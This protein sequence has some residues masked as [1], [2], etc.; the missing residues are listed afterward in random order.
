M[1]LDAHVHLKHG[2]AAATEHPVATIIHVMDEIGIDRSVVFAM[3][4]TTRRSIEM[5]AEAVAAYPDRLIP[6]A[7]A[8]PH[9]ERPVVEELAEA[10]RLGFKGIKVHAGEARLTDY[11]ADPVFRLAGE[12]GVP[13]LVDFGGDLKAAERLATDFPDTR[14][15][16]AHFGRYL[17]TDGSLMRECLAVAERRPNV[18]VDAS[19]VVMPWIIAEGVQRIGAGRILWGSDGP[20][21]MPDLITFALDPLR[22]IQSLGL[23]PEDEALVLGGTAAKLLGLGEG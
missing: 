13:C 6:Y 17:C 8:L 12:V 9:Y 1:I 11:L 22:Q 5:A 10:I 23:K 18:W 4:T 20:H 15:V 21:T 16:I 14:I 3:S 19:G 7:Y 2:D